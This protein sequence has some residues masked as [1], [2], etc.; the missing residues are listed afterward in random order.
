M[1]LIL[2]IFIIGLLTYFLSPYSVWWTGMAVAFIVTFV[3]PSS[4]L[5]A[6]VAGFLGIGLVWM[7]FAFVLDTANAAVFSSKVAAIMSP[8]DSSTKL[9]M[10][11][12]AVGGLSGGFA[13]LS[14]TLLK[15]LVAKP[16]K[17]SLYS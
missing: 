3:S 4:S 17:K 15:D 5:N 14:G 1:K 2:R 6:F 13:A 16:K 10:L 12:G 8:F 7:G 11:T 9:I